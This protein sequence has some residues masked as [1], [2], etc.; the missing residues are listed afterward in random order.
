VLELPNAKKYDRQKLAAAQVTL[1]LTEREKKTGINLKDYLTLE[2]TPSL[3]EYYRSFMDAGELK[4]AAGTLSQITKETNYSSYRYVLLFDQVERDVD[5]FEELY[6]A[7]DSTS[8]EADISYILREAI[9][10]TTN[11][12]KRD[13][14]AQIVR[15]DKHLGIDRGGQEDH[16]RISQHINSLA[17]YQLLCGDYKECETNILVGIDLHPENKYL[18]T[19]LAP[20]LLLQGKY[21]SAKRAYKKYAKKPFDDSVGFPLFADAFLDDFDILEK[22][23][24]LTVQQKNDI[25]KIRKILDN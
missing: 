10:D 22:F 11:T 1:Y 15:L 2:D 9:K 12:G 14:Y 21:K 19:N 8:V 5:F 20:A 24:H 13:H 25:G 7:I 17:Y 6:G 4:L 23:D 16:L 3:A 18:Y